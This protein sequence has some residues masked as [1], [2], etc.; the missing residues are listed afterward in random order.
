MP[1]RNEVRIIGGK[2]KRRKLRFPDR[3]T[4]RPTLDRVRVTVEH[5]EVDREQQD[6]ERREPGPDLRRRDRLHHS[7]VGT[8]STG[9]RHT[10]S[11][12]S[13]TEPLTSRASPPRPCEA[14]HT[15]SAP[16]RSAVVAIA[17]AGSASRTTWTSKRV[18]G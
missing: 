17:C 12:R 15:T 8:T 7:T 11:R 2:W 3:P 13:V 9:R 6:H 18:S 16:T 1:L 5:D 14:M 10:W 4:L